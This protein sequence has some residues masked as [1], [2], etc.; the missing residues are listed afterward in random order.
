MR[1]VTIR[2][3]IYLIKSLPV[4]Q[5]TCIWPWQVISR[6]LFYLKK[7]V[8]S[9]LSL[10]L[11]PTSKDS[12]LFHCQELFCDAVLLKETYLSLNCRYVF[13]QLCNILVPVNSYF[14]SNCLLLCSKLQKF[15]KNPPRSTFISPKLEIC[16]GLRQ[17]LQLCRTSDIPQRMVTCSH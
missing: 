11:L 3:R 8:L 2:D 13:W 4:V 12:N 15:P 7:N 17:L 14:F 10:F 16:K 9:L 5:L 1:S 6:L